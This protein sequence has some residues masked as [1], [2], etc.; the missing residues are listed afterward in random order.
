[1]CEVWFTVECEI[2]FCAFVVIDV[3][4]ENF[5]ADRHVFHVEFVHFGEIHHGFDLQV[6]HIDR[7]DRWDLVRFA[8]CV[9]W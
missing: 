5:C 1:M 4:E 6:I 8:L 9:C 3:V 7:D 2:Y